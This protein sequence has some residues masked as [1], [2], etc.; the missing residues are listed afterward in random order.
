M[1]NKIRVD[2]M[3]LQQDAVAQNQ[4]VNSDQDQATIH[5]ES[6]IENYHDEQ[7]DHEEVKNEIAFQDT[8]IGM[9]IVAWLLYLKRKKF[10]AM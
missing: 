6:A 10:E 1:R 5:L 9:E 4:I 2:G 7:K 3:E 8:G